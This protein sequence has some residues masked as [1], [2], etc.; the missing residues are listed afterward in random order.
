MLTLYHPFS[1]HSRGGN[2]ACTVMFHILESETP[3]P[4]PIALVLAYPALDFNF[5]SWMTPDHL[6]TL[7]T[8][9]ST[10]NIPGLEEG[11]DHMRHR[12]PLAVVDDREPTSP[13]IGRTKSWKKSIMRLASTSTGSL[14]GLTTTDDEAEEQAEADKSLQDRV[15]TPFQEKSMESLQRE[16]QR[17]V[18]SAEKKEGQIKAPIGT[19]L[20]MTSRTGYFQ[21]RIISP[22]MVSP[23]TRFS[24][25]TWLSR[26]KNL[27][28]SWCN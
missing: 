1:P 9:Q 5:T 28:K 3:I 23:S 17:A 25:L 16:L 18:N 4:H 22:S 24:L 10:S 19:R 15:K 12:S 21:D 7:R 8:E 13:R 26:V 27:R 6:R 2:V 11:K 14:L 20:T